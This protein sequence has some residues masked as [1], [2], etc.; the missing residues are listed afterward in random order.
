M[1]IKT[2]SFWEKDW[3]LLIVITFFAFAI[4][5]STLNQPTGP[6]AEAVGI[7]EAFGTVG[8]GSSIIASVRLKD[9]TLIQAEA[10]SKSMPLIGR[11]AHMRVYH[12][13]ISRAKVY[14]IYRT[15]TPNQAESII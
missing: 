7:I 9:G 10:T 12:R 4:P 11:I 6:V 5:Y 13:F 3:L 14:Q 8:K 15:D 2:S 1:T